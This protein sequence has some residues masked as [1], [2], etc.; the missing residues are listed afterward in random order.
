MSFKVY[1]IVLV[2]VLHILGAAFV[3]MIALW[4]TL[5]VLWWGLIVLEGIIFF[6]SALLARL[7][8]EEDNLIAEDN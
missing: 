5:D 8:S 4:G 3:G 2:I 1:F 6:V 7:F